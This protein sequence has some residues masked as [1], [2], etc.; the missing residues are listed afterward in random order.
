MNSH[1]TLIIIVM[2]FVAVFFSACGSD[3]AKPSVEAI[4]SDIAHA[5]LLS[6]LSENYNLDYSGAVEEGRI[7]AGQQSILDS[8]KMVYLVQIPHADEGGLIVENVY[9][10]KVFIVQVTKDGEY[11]ADSNTSVLL[12]PENYD[13]IDDLPYTMVTIPTEEDIWFVAVRI[14]DNQY[15]AIFN[16]EILQLNDSGITVL[17]VVGEPPSGDLVTI[18]KQDEL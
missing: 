3:S 16:D 13:A 14:Y 17:L 12:D 11:I 15:K 5:T 6:Y 2:I 1:K 10:V 8:S 4:N 7:L 18:K 9:Q